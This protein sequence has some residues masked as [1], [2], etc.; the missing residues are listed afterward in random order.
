M[1]NYKIRILLGGVVALIISIPVMWLSVFYKEVVDT[2]AVMHEPIERDVSEK[3]IEGVIFDEL[4]PFSVLLLGVDEREGDNGRSDTI[5]VITVNPTDQSTKMIS[6]PRDTHIGLI[7][8][9]KKE[10]INHA[11]AFGG[12]AMAINSIET[13]LDIPIDYVATINREGFESIVDAV[14]G[15]SVTNEVDFQVYDFVFPEGT[16]QLDGHSALTYVPT[17]TNYRGSFA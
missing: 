7:G 13:L 10:K 14:G 16:I 3:R 6:I 11:Y 12:T 9:V 17:K 8:R 1:N 4:F 15:I 5:V 2:V